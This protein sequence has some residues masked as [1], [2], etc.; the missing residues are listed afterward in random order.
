MHRRLLKG[1]MWRWY[2]EDVGIPLAGALMLGGIT[3]LLL[4]DYLSRWATFGY[5][6][7]SWFLILVATIILAAHVR[8]EVFR[9]VSSLFL[10]D[11][12]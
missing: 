10:V 4:P 6:A 11:Y 2:R 7:G 9:R 12:A 3:R 1:E 8:I 5:I